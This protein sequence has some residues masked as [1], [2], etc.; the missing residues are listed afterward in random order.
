MSCCSSSPESS[1]SSEDSATPERV[2]RPPAPAIRSEEEL[3]AW[4]RD[5]R[6]VPG[7]AVPGRAVPGRAGQIEAL[8]LESHPVY[9]GRGAAAVTRMRGWL[10]LALDELTPEALPFVLEELES[11]HDA[12]LTAAAAAVLRRS[13]PRAE[14]TQPLLSA[15]LYIRSRDD[16]VTLEAYGGYGVAGERTT[17]VAEL[18]KTLEWLGP[19]ARVALPR[20][21]ELRREVGPEASWSA[22][23]DRT[24]DVLES[25][26]AESCCAASKPAPA[27]SARE[28]EG[29][30]DPS[31]LADLEFQDQDGAAVRFGDFLIGRPS[32]VVFFYT[33]CDNPT[34]CAMT[35]TRLGRA[36]RLLEEQGLSGAIRT[37]AITYDPGY[38]LPP[39]LKRYAEIWGAR[40]AENHR[41][42]RLP[43]GFE[44]LRAHFDLGVNYVSSVVNRHQIEAYVLDAE[45]RVRH[46][47][48]R[49]QWDEGELIARASSLIS[50]QLQT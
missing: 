11:S 41:M 14:W 13:A 35:V 19:R 3:I 43:E 17:A 2:K 27:S 9:D 34:K 7:R 10:L 33:R 20:L 18:L 36:Q 37:A 23:L 21:R 46:A 50:H 32:L 39:R 1:A 40:P 4:L 45:G 28:I 16:S 42:L 44:R 12:Y 6:A 24:I 49:R 48:T 5:S 26:E 31:S 22:A 38:D 15:L 8:L 30:A 47:A 25:A 29:A